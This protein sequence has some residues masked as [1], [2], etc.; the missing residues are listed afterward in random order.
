MLGFSRSPTDT[1]CR[2]GLDRR[3]RLTLRSRSHPFGQRTN[4]RPRRTFPWTDRC[5]ALRGQR[6]GMAHVE[7]SIPLGVRGIGLPPG[8]SDIT[9]AAMALPSTQAVLPPQFRYLTRQMKS[10]RFPPVSSEQFLYVITSAGGADNRCRL[11]VVAALERSIEVPAAGTFRSRFVKEAIS[12]VGRALIFEG[13]REFC[14]FAVVQ[15]PPA[16]TVEPPSGPCPEGGSVFGLDGERSGRSAPRRR[17]PHPTTVKYLRPVRVEAQV[18]LA[19]RARRRGGQFASLSTKAD[20]ASGKTSRNID[21]SLTQKADPQKTGTIRRPFARK[22]TRLEP[23]Q[24]AR[25]FGGQGT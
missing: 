20:E 14:D 22:R 10:L 21:S 7:M 23:E 3:W 11:G 6:A 2:V 13:L 25:N 15:F 16:S 18:H 17:W 1:V 4:H 5:R 12:R 24:A 9:T 19:R 8:S